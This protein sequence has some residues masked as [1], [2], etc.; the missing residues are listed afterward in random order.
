MITDPKNTQWRWAPLLSGEEA[1]SGVAFSKE[2]H[3]NSVLEL[4]KLHYFW[5]LLKKY[6]GE[7]PIQLFNSLDIIQLIYWMAIAYIYIYIY[8]YIYW[9]ER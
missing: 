6:N 1:V 2:S 5:F 7:Q 8:I 4:K 9:V 3:A